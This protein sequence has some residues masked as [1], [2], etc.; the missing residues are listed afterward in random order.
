MATKI[1]LDGYSES[2]RSVGYKVYQIT[3]WGQTFTCS[4]NTVLSSCKFFL[5]RVGSPTG[6]CYAKIYEMT[7]TFGTDGYP[8]GAELAKSAVIDVTKISD[9]G[10]VLTEFTFT[11]ENAI[12]LTPKNYCIAFYRTG[13]DTNNCIAFGADYTSFSHA[14]NSF[15]YY[16]GWVTEGI[17]DI[18]DSVF[19]VYGTTVDYSITA[20]GGV[21]TL[22]GINATPK[23]ARTVAITKVEF[24][25]TGIDNA[26]GTGKG[27]Q[28]AV[29]EFAL[30][31]IDNVYAITLTYPA[32]VTAFVLTGKTTGLKRGYTISPELGEFTLTLKDNDFGTGTGFVVSNGGF[33]LTGNGVSFT[34]GNLWT[35]Q[36]KNTATWTNETEATATWINEDELDV[37]WSNNQGY[38]LT[39]DGFY[40]LQENGD[41]IVIAKFYTEKDSWTN[42]TENTSTWTKI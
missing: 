7:G 10:Y 41:K 2:N 38:L 16:G 6:D 28:A 25:L 29:G 27:I 33:I 21:F 31:G 4:I 12:L 42:E 9:A 5:K 39:E 3:H 30:T 24:T 1:T 26:F 15:V 19:Y 40:L 14:G 20:S 37:E 8:D 32:T 35:K 22:T 18:M 11:G 13:G 17:A 36:G 34:V 23:G